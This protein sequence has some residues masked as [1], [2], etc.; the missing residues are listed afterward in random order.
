MALLPLVVGLSLLWMLPQTVEAMDVPTL[1]RWRLDPLAL[2]GCFILPLAAVRPQPLRYGFRLALAVGGLM[3]AILATN[4][5]L[6][7]FAV[8]LASLLVYDGL[9]LRWF[10]ALACF[11]LITFAPSFLSS[12]IILHVTILMA[13]VGSGGVPWSGGS[14]AGEAEIVLRPFWFVVLL[15]SLVL[16]PWPVATVIVV[17][18]LGTVLL[19][20]G[21]WSVLRTAPMVTRDRMLAALLVMTLVAIAQ[22]TTLGI[23]AALWTLTMYA[24]LV[25]LGPS[26]RLA[27]LASVAITF[28]VA[29]WWTAGAVG[30]A[31]SFLGVAA[32]VLTTVAACV[33]A[34]LGAAESPRRS[35]VT[36]FVT[37]VALVVGM[38]WLTMTVALPVAQQLG[39]GLTAP[40]L[41]DVW[42]FI[43]VSAMDAGHRRVTLAPSIVLACLFVV[44]WAAV[45]LLSRLRGLD[46]ARPLGPL[47]EGTH[48][49]VRARV[50]WLR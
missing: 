18:T 29:G 6:Q 49:D 48:V 24:L 31:G 43:G 20:M 9:S 1:G 17:T 40:G 14:G 26:R 19:I 35:S 32:V 10:A 36:Y 5:V 2:V 50:W 13:L 21:A 41:L 33:A 15:R 30:A 28:G 7:L 44:L 3:G 42:S 46:S 47:D 4:P 45:W 37:L 8:V 22:N 12:S 39:A 27:P 23:V 16:E 11:I 38:P 25:V 34:L